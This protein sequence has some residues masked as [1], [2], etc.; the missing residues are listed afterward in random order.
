MNHS[1]YRINPLIQTT[2][3]HTLQECRYCLAYMSESITGLIDADTPID[4]YK[5][6]QAINECV[7]LALHYEYYRLQEHQQ[8]NTTG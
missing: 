1:N 4:A 3:T 8:P 2:T 7:Q 6:L 5:G